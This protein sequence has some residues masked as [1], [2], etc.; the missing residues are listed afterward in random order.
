MDP[1]SDGLGFKLKPELPKVFLDLA[2]NVWDV[3]LTL[4]I[5]RL[6]DFTG[7]CPKSLSQMLLRLWRFFWQFLLCFYSVFVTFFVPLDVINV[8]GVLKIGS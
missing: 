2:S 8:V 3:K 7:I 5:L 4:V 6:L 1:G